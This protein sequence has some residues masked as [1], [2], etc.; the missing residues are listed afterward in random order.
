MEP[1]QY[2]KIRGDMEKSGAGPNVG[3]ALGGCIRTKV[4]LFEITSV[5]SVFVPYKSKT[6]VLVSRRFQVQYCCDV[7]KTSEWNIKPATKLKARLLCVETYDRAENLAVEQHLC[8]YQASTQIQHS[9][10]IFGNT[11]QIQH[12]NTVQVPLID[13]ASTGIGCQSCSWSADQGKILCPCPR[14]RLRI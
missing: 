5:E 2:Q 12:K 10:S 1:A 14:P 4:C 3:K 11:V 6:I 7:K 9:K 13:W 8:L